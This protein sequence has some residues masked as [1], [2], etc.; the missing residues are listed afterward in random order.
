MCIFP[1]AQPMLTSFTLDLSLS[2]LQLTFDASVNA[3]TCNVSQLTLVN[4]SDPMTTTSMYSLSTATCIVSPVLPGQL[5]VNLMAQEIAGLQSDPNLATSIDNTYIT[6][7]EFIQDDNGIY[8]PPILPE[9]ALQA[10][11][12]K[13]E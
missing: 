4:S 9:A 2:H 13:S 7:S 11:G 10:T 3:S 8:N 12:V 6:I 5:I 1:S